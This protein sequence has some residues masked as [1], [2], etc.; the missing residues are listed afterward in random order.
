MR[1]LEARSRML[2]F[3]LSRD[4]YERAEEASRLQ[5]YRSVAL[6]A[7]SAV[8]ASTG[9]ESG[10]YDSQIT[11]LYRKV[12][13]L[14]TELNFVSESFTTLGRAIRLLHGATQVSLDADRSVRNESDSN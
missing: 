8:L 11:E 7:R 9:T 1:N 12:N 4:E 14:E 5:G 13:H 2:S 3:R 10:S 6:F